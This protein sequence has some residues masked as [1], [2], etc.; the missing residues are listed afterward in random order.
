[1]PAADE[2]VSFE[3][4]IKPLFRPTDRESMAW[5]F[6]LASYDEV[7][8]NAAAILERLGDGS[9]PCNGEWPREQVNASGDGPRRVCA[10]SR[11]LVALYTRVLPEPILERGHGS[12]DD[13]R[14]LVERILR[15]AAATSAADRVRARPALVH[16]ERSEQAMDRYQRAQQQLQTSDGEELRHQMSIADSDRSREIAEAGARLREYS[17][18]LDQELG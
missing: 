4:D 7:K 16:I 3:Q 18:W 10:S 14:Q 15:E 1:M 9:M 12:T 17:D 11:Q 6:D 8:A 2:R 5:A 13:A